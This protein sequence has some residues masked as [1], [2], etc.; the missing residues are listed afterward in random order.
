MPKM[1]SLS[2]HGDQDKHSELA[3]NKHSEL[4]ANKHSKVAANKEVTH[5]PC[6]SN[7]WIGGSG[8]TYILTYLHKE[9]KLPNKRLSGN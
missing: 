6:Q 4:A 7:L 8:H 9:W 1:L 2:P 5:L 3:A